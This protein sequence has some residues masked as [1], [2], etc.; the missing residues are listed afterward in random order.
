MR[1][2]AGGV[3]SA[4]SLRYNINIISEKKSKF[5]APGE[6]IMKNNGKNLIALLL[7]C[8]LLFSSCGKQQP[9][10]EHYEVVDGKIVLVE[11]DEG[12]GADIIH[13]GYDDSAPG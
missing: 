3:A 9:R 11:G 5:N 6:L 1:C 8:C 7:L 13:T 12:D 2:A 4:S 10:T